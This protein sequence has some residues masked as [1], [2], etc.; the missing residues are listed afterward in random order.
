MRDRYFVYILTNDRHTVL[1]TGVTNNL[2]R[3]A[4]EHRAGLSSFTSRYNVHKLCS[5][6]SSMRSTTRSHAKSRSR[7]ARGGRKSHS[8]T[9]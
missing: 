3:R 4:G 6:R 9:A 8:S 2:P 1:Y 5:S 7:A